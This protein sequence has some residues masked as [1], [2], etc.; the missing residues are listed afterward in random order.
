MAQVLKISP[1]DLV[2]ELDGVLWS[3]GRT[4]EELIEKLGDREFKQLAASV[5]TARLARWVQIITE[6]LT[7][8]IAE[9]EGDRPE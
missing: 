6:E 2:A 7:R 1:S 8:R 9:P 3:P 5:E 4:M